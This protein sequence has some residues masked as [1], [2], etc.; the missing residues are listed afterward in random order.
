MES[1]EL[2]GIFGD[3]DPSQYAEEVTRRWGHTGAYRESARRT[4][5]Y[6]EKDWERIRDENAA[7][8]ARM[9]AVFDRGVVPVDTEAMDVAEAARRAIDR[10]FYPCSHAMHATLAEGYVSDPRFRSY[11]EKQREGLAE[12]F[13]AAIRANAARAASGE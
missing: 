11:Y 9:L 2:C 5:R 12:W 13:A 6:A 8:L 7:V 4:S 10:A 3:F 1:E